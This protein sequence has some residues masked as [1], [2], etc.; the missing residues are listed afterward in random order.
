MKRPTPSYWESAAMALVG[1]FVPLRRRA[2]APRHCSLGGGRLLLLPSIHAN[3]R[4]I[5]MT[6]LHFEGCLKMVEF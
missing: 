1:S 2:G 3:L 5:L 4:T 6:S